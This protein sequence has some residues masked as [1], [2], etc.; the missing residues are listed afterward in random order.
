MRYTVTRN[1][2][3]EII[4][5]FI[6]TNRN[7]TT[8]YL[9]MTPIKQ[10]YNANRLSINEHMPAMWKINNRQ[11]FLSQFNNA[12]PL[13]PL[14][15][16]ANHSTKTTAFQ[17]PR[18]FYVYRPLGTVEQRTEFIFRIKQCFVYWR[19][20]YTCKHWKDQ[21]CKKI[22]HGIFSEK[23]IGYSTKNLWDA[24]LETMNMSTT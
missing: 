19:E 1:N 20:V 23:R 18:L 5:I 16:D 3:G 13:S 22:R 24:N 14:W 6:T 9:P 4:N 15:W 17:T 2:K 7:W 10:S 21:L 8:W 11:S 12:Q